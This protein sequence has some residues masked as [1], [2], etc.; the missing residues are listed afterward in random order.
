MKKIN[1]EFNTPKSQKTKLYKFLDDKIG[2]EIF[3][4]DGYVT[5]EGLP[6][7]ECS[8]GFV[9]ATDDPAV[10]SMN[11]FEGKIVGAATIYFADE[12][13]KET[14][15]VL[16]NFISEN[17]ANIDFLNGKS[18]MGQVYQTYPHGLGMIK[19]ANGDF[20]IGYFENGECHGL[21]LNYD[22][23]NNLVYK[24][25]YYHNE[26]IISSDNDQ[27]IVDAL[28]DC[29]FDLKQM[30]EC[31]KTEK[32]TNATIEVDDI[33]KG[34]NNIEKNIIGQKKA[35][36]IINNHLLLSL[37]CA[38][39]ENK[40]IT[41]MVFTGPTGVGKTEMAKQIS[42]NIF[43]KKPFTIDFANFHDKFM[44]SSL[45]GSPAGYVGSDNEPEFLKYIR[46][47]SETGG[48]LLFEEIDKAH[49][50]CLNF[51]M[52]ILDEGEVLDSHN[53]AYSVKNFIVLATTNMSANTTRTLGF[54]DKDDDVKNQ[55]AN[56]EQTGMKREQLAR[57]GLVVEFGMFNKEEKRALTLMALDKAVARI[58][59]I[60]DY[61]IN[62]K[63][64]DKF[65][66]DL[67]SKMNNTFGV[68]DIQSRASSTINEQLANFIRNN[69]ERNIKVKFK[70]LDDVEIKGVSQK[71]KKEKNLSF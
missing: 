64:E 31:L 70:S 47:N 26:C 62:I 9:N 50:D 61:K 15:K 38:R 22:K 35:I 19:E 48:V 41:S 63:F 23:N 12:D 71:D 20:T 57:F 53:K 44:L 1:I 13:G 8:I 46:E 14:P 45:I 67:A 28:K 30:W 3:A 16:F 54:S 21:F 49:E 32:K 11:F 24:S 43:N 18:Y 36:K 4:F 59:T 34:L 42:E 37:L 25:V 66:D 69:D 51:F 68:R 60:K 58:R 2:Q 7:G 56:T 40:P 33:K 39:Q 10:I 29:E 6:H 52:R 55:M 65:V 5:D 17:Y 27:E